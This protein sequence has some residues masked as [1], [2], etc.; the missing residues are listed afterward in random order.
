MYAVFDG[1]VYLK[2]QFGDMPQPNT[3]P[4]LR[5]YEPGRTGEAFES[6]AF[7]A[8]FDGQLREK[9]TGKGKIIGDFHPRDGDRAYP[10]VAHAET[11][12]LRELPP[13][14][15]GNLFRP[16]GMVPRS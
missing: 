1:V 11:N 2:P 16:K 7:P 14:L 15:I 4:E 10:R 6:I 12:D 9:D 3:L 5:S 8:P 13:D